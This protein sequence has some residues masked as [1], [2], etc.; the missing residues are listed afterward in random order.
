M[1][2]RWAWLA[3]AAVAVSPMVAG[4]LSAQD[5][6]GK[7]QVQYA[8]FDW[9]VIETEHFLVH[10]YPSERIAAMD[11]ARMAE[12]AYNRLSRILGHE[13][14]EKKPIMV[15]ASRADFGQN[16]VTGDLGE[17]TGGVTEPLRDR[18]LL[19]F[20]GDYRTFEHVLTHEMV[21]E[22]QFDVFQRG[23]GAGGAIQSLSQVNPSLWFMEGMAEYL[24]IGPNDPHT[25]TV[26]RDAALN[27]HLP[28]IKQM[29]EQPDEYFPYRYGEAFWAY[30]A[31]RWGD[32]IVGSI[33]TA[34]PSMGVERAFKHETGKS[35]DDLG[36][37]W[38]EAMQVQHLPQ[39]AQLERPRKFAQPLLTERRSGGQIF[40]APALSPDGN[41]VAFLS[42]GS[43]LRGQ[44]FID[45]WL[46]D[47]RTGKR[48]ARLVKSTFDPN[49]QELQLLYS[50]SSFSP[51]GKRLAFT[52]LGEGREILYILDVA[53]RKRIKR[54]ALDLD[55]ITSPSWSP[56][57]QHLVF[58]GNRGGITDLFVVDADGKHLRQLT[59]DKYGDIQPQ[60][61]PDGKTIAFATDREGA[62]VSLLRFPKMRIALYHVDDG[63]VEVI[64]GQ[65]GLNINPMWAPDSRSLAYVSNRSGIENI[66]LY[67]FGDR[68]HYQLTRVVG[69]VTAFTEVSPVISW[70]RA[71][72]R[73][74]FTYYEDGNYAVWSVDNP[75]LL[76]REP[77]RAP[78]PT[79]VARSGMAA[80]STAIAKVAAMDSAPSP[81]GASSFY[82][83][84][85]GFRASSDTP[86]VA[87][88][89]SADAPISVAAL[90]DSG[91]LALPDTMRFKKYKYHIRF[92]PD[93]VARPTV[94]YARDNFGSG[95]FG[96]TA[97]VLSDMV[98][99][100]QLAF[101]GAING[102]ISEAQV[103]AGYTNLSRRLQYT[104]G[105]Y[106]TPYYFGNPPLL[107]SVTIDNGDGT[108]QQG[109]QETQIIT[110]YIVRQAFATAI[111][112]F[113]RFTR[114]ELG[115][116][117]TN[118]DRTD[119]VFTRL[120]DGTL[121]FATPYDER[122]QNSRTV[123]YF[124]PSLAYVSDNVLWGMTA[125]IYGRR[126]R[127]QVTPALGNFHWVE[128]LADYRRYDPILFNFLTI[129]TRAS[130]SLSVGRD[131]DSV[132][133]YIGYSDVLRG[134]E[135]DTF[136]A[137]EANCPDQTA[138]GV[139]RCSPLLGSRVAYASAELRFPLL[140]GG[141]VA[142][143]IP[144]PPIEGA[145]FYDV[146]TAWFSGQTLEF[147][148]MRPTDA[149][150]VR[151][152]LTSYGFGV[153]VNLFNYAIL[154]WDY[155]IPL[156][157]PGKHGFWRFSLYPPF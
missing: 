29:T 95:V 82:R 70:S 6:F 53:R 141:G 24:S 22:F 79:T 17:G 52:A 105:V 41:Y 110:R 116:G 115:L 103:F 61:S 144:V 38:R 43:F 91:E 54:I 81:A 56:D 14:R 123:N 147:H 57:G 45:L 19:P 148:R 77:Y 75:R 18:M 145:F 118:L 120:L 7:N 134:Y 131:A 40:L 106:Q 28:T 111:Y 154:R 101:A 89:K 55:G 139:Y 13:F 122:E 9:Q 35:L 150:N 113:D 30:I 62:D 80:D 23:R 5:Y 39:I 78:E 119:L 125:P 100:N 2:R 121:T 155:A 138:T 157:A 60:W 114:A 31:Q 16:N 15:F 73:L 92:S 3:G 27:G 132:R 156:E 21:H 97:I 142:G 42:N 85:T 104:T 48:V 93:Y 109:Y 65:D 143:V 107:Q 74:V 47:A 50:Q 34:V 130:A 133:K 32:E 117:W 4:P 71:S 152:L 67:D 86:A 94:G 20:T 36:D 151:G 136:Q 11:A 149:S 137:T 33:L 44:V 96:G 140:R 68:Q 98:G 37:E 69:G 76:K 12:R 63:R 10:Y 51:D 146:G 49:Y 108:S 102:R 66:F 64:P 126:Y 46:A 128:Y 88:T 135:S 99:N 84:S 59:D 83:S 124:Q 72:D 25:S 127:F 87:E 129:A 26:I 153:R 8:H 1:M 58:S 90:L 112:P